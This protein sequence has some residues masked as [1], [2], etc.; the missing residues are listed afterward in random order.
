MSTS[1]REQLLAAG[2][3]SSQQVEQA[4]QQQRQQERRQA[5]GPSKGSP[6][7][8]ADRQ[9]AAERAREAKAARDRELSRQR[10]E[11]LERKQRALQ[12]RQLIAGHRLPVLETEG[13]FN[14][15]DRGK[16]RRMAV[17]AARR[18]QII[19]GQIVI[20]RYEG[21]YDLVPATIAERIRECDPRVL[22]ACGTGP[23]APA[24][25]TDDDPYRDFAVPDDLIW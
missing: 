7:P 17:D 21:R 9:R 13:R 18:E 25:P 3:V 5:R 2:L 6:G 4:E 20:V 22:V 14:F 10:Q 11:A 23:A 12:I 1:L 16:V 15:I 24:A 8:D 19:G